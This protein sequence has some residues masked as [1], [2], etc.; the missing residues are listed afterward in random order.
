MKKIAIAVAVMAVAV[1]AFGANA[2]FGTN[3]GNQVAGKVE[4]KAKD[5]ANAVANNEI[6]KQTNDLLA[7]EGCT[8]IT[9]ANL[10]KCSVK[11]GGTLTP[12][13]EKV[14]VSVTGVGK[15]DATR[16]L[17]DDLSSQVKTVCSSADLSYE[18]SKKGKKTELQLSV[19]AK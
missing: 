1:W 15:D 7:K 17:Y 2:G 3:L 12:L 6:A 9:S 13:K 11:I 4:S 19:L 5:K 10:K 14:K 8:T 18:T 16:A